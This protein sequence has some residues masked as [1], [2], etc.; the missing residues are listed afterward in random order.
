MHVALKHDDNPNFY[1]DF[2]EVDV[3]PPPGTVIDIDGQEY[4]VDRLRLV[5]AVRQCDGGGQDWTARY[6]ADLAQAPGEPDS[7][8]LCPHGVPPEFCGNCHEECSVHGGIPGNPPCN[9]MCR[10]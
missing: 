7:D 8:A 5:V 3:P 6:V 9:S 4:T 2:V 10:A 1:P